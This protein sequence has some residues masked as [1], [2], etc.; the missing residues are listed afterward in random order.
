MVAYEA[1]LLVLALQYYEKQTKHYKYLFIFLK[2]FFLSL[3][4]CCNPFL[5][6]FLGL[7][8]I[9]CLCKGIKSEHMNVV[10]FLMGIFSSILWIIVV[11]FSHGGTIKQFF[12]VVPELLHDSSHSVDGNT[13]ATKVY[14]GLNEYFFFHGYIIIGAAI[15]VMIYRVWKK[16]IGLKWKR[17]YFAI[18]TF[19]MCMVLGRNIMLSD[20]LGDAIFIISFYFVLLIPIADITSN[21]LWID[22]IGAGIILMFS[23]FLASNQPRAA[24]SSGAIIVVIGGASMFRSVL[25]EINIDKKY[26]AL[27]VAMVMM[28][29]CIVTVYWKVYTNWN[30][31]FSFRLPEKVACGPARGLY[32]TEEHKKEVEY[33]CEL[34]GK[35]EDEGYLVTNN[36][37]LYLTANLR[38]G[39][40]SEW[41]DG[42]ENQAQRV[43]QY[44]SLYPERK[45]NY[46][47]AYGEGNNFKEFTEWQEIDAYEKQGEDMY[48]IFQRMDL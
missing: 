38:C 36:M 40:Y 30:D 3:A 39:M 48:Q 23:F 43:E 31:K 34:A 2:G 19:Y 11:I 14:L 1:L 27:G 5:S 24:G 45:P 21:R 32:T 20:N 44:Y 9:W 15:L 13:L 46:I 26:L 33:M 37:L 6:V 41:Y 4:V 17:I 28:P 29:V 12:A 22:V 47:V 42:I 25:R 18:Q 7:K 35:M 10:L 16:E 8:I